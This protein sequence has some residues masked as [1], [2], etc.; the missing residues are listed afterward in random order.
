LNS[1]SYFNIRDGAV[2]VKVTMGVENQ[3]ALVSSLGETYAYMRVMSVKAVSPPVV[4]KEGG[5]RVVLDVDKLANKAHAWCK[6][7]DSIFVTAASVYGG[8]TN[9]LMECVS[10]AGVTG[11]TTLEVSTNGVDFT[12]NGFMVE[13]TAAANVTLTTPHM[14]PINGDSTLMIHGLGFSTSGLTG[15]YC[16]YGGSNGMESWSVTQGTLVGSNAITCKVPARGAGFRAVEIALSKDGEMSRSG[17]QVQYTA[18]GTVESVYPSTGV[19]TG[20][21]IVTVIGTGFIAGVS[22]CKFG[23]TAS[24]MGTVVATTEM[25]CVAPA[26]VAGAVNVKVAMGSGDDTALVSALDEVFVYK[27]APH[28]ISVEPKYIAMVGG[29][30]VSM[31]ANGVSDGANS[32]CKFNGNVIVKA[33]SIQ[34]SKT[35]SIIECLSVAG[36]VGNTSVEW[37]SNG[38]DFTSAG[39]TLERIDHANVT[40]VLPNIV[41]VH[42]EATIVLRGVGFDTSKYSMGVYCSFGAANAH[43]TWTYAAGKVIDNTAVSC[44]VAGRSA[45]FRAVEI[46]L[47][48]N[49]EMSRTGVQVMYASVG[50]VA[51]VYPSVGSVAE[52]SVVTVSGSGF[53]A[54][55]TSCKFGTNSAITAE[56]ISTT[57]ARCVTP[58]THRGAVTLE[59]GLGNANEAPLVSTSNKMFIFES[60][61]QVL[62]MKSAVAMV[63]GG[64]NIKMSLTG[65]ADG[66]EAWC[67]IDGRYTVTAGMVQGGMVECVTV[68]GVTGYTSVEVSANGQEFSSNGFVIQTVMNANVSYVLPGDVPITG[69]TTIIVRGTGF[70]SYNVFCGFGASTTAESWTQTAATMLSATAVSCQVPAREAGFRALEV[71]MSKNG[72]MSR[73]GAQVMFSNVGLVTSVEPSTGFA[74]GGSIVTLSGTGFVAGVTACKFGS[75]NAV[76]ATIVSSTE[77]RCLSPA[78]VLGAVVVSIAMNGDANTAARSVSGKQFLYTSTSTII[79]ASPMLFTALGG[80]PLVLTVS[81]AHDSSAA[82]CRFGNNVV[83]S[84]DTVSSG[85]VHCISTAAVEGNTTLEVSING[86]DF[87]SD[88]FMVQSIVGTNVSSILPGYNPVYGGSTVSLRGSGFGTYGNTAFCNFGSSTSSESWQVSKASMMTGDRIECVIPARNAGFRVVEVSMSKDGDLSRSGLQIQYATTGV[89]ESMYPSSGSIAGGSIVTVTGV[90]FVAGVTACKFGSAPVVFA[91]VIS[92]TEARCV[93]PAG[94]RGVTVLQMALGDASVVS[95]T[96]DGKSFLYTTVETT[97]GITP[98]VALADGGSVL[99]VESTISDGSQAFCL[100]GGRVVVS[101]SVTDGAVECISV[102]SIKGNVTVEV[103]SNGQDFTSAGTLVNNFDIANVTMITPN[104]LPVIGGSSSWRVGKALMPLGLKVLTVPL[105]LPHHQKLGLYLLAL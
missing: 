93:T 68:A 95:S 55:V 87:T 73:S 43:E 16:S 80:T 24:V 63:H 97:L 91:T 31:I 19:A 39:F 13:S 11:N 78:S 21:T 26:G 9:S 56:V 42:G 8:Q 48:K 69:G 1:N 98:I 45:G 28:V 14:V 59:V 32:F 100:F 37:S 65:I 53:I 27:I 35:G 66:S 102:A 47:N 88:S 17:V 38:E 103:S 90:G 7:G 101:A 33:G 40:Y 3:E 105:V 49:G 75:T 4:I 77:A 67:L 29:S 82:W 84:A 10:V 99:K 70:N 61:V 64:S 72:E 79:G 62:D 92:T 20:G 85:V 86:Q 2:D 94:A 51:H 12:S 71:A 36:V 22:G 5:S 50:S 52:G 57:E 54:G 46:A 104:V 74:V 44:T 89:I 60:A 18:V 34:G 83:V 15:I 58:V 96:A 25:R 30:K 76:E 6:F 81:G 23:S 41:P